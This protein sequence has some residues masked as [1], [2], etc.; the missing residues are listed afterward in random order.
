M[1]CV[2][3]TH[4]NV[5]LSIATKLLMNIISADWFLQMFRALLQ[6]QVLRIFPHYL[7]NISIFS[8]R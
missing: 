4:E 7:Q 6:G 1:L 8:S 3:R 2:D 5:P